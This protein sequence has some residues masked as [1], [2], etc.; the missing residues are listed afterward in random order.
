MASACTSPPYAQNV[1]HHELG[2]TD[3]EI[4]LTRKFRGGS[5]VTV[6]TVFLTLIKAIKRRTS[7]L[8]SAEYAFQ[9]TR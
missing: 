1:D 3:S 4:F 9:T 6:A 7:T 8:V 5:A 2:K